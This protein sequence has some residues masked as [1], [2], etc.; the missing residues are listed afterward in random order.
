MF[1]C[2]IKGACSFYTGSYCIKNEDSIKWL[3]EYIDVSFECSRPGYE[4]FLYRFILSNN[5]STCQEI[6][7]KRSIDW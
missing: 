4:C 3:K 2:R 6:K 7:N 5:K 1:H